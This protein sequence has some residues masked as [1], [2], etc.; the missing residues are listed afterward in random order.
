L[1]L[2]GP[3]SGSRVPVRNGV[4]CPN[5]KPDRINDGS[6]SAVTPRGIAVPL[7]GDVARVFVTDCVK[8]IEGLLTEEQLRKK[9]QLE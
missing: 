4:C 6:G 5:D 3:A 8:F 1:L 9:Y 7:D 2:G